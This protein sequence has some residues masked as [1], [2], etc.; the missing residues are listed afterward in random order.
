M[1][2]YFDYLVKIWSSR[3]TV[4]PVPAIGERAAVT[5]DAPQSFNLIVQRPD[6]VGILLGTNMTR[7]QILSLARAA[8][9]P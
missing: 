3:S 8:V 6:G 7:A 4:E 2:Q 9:T 5:S 1:P